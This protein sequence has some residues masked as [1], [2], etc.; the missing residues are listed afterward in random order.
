[1]SMAPPRFMG[2]PS[3][4]NSRFRLVGQPEP[5]APARRCPIYLANW[6]VMAFPMD[7]PCI[8][9]LPSSI[10]YFFCIRAIKAA[11]AFTS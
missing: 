8:N 11:A 5:A 7:I 2:F 6:L 10:L 1:M 9:I 3:L 4:S